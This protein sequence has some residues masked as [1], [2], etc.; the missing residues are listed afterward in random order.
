MTTVDQ[1]VA[2][3]IATRQLLAPTMHDREMQWHTYGQY[4]SRL[5]AYMR[6]HLSY[7]AQ[8]QVEVMHLIMIET[9]AY[10][11][12]EPFAVL[13]RQ[14]ANT[15]ELPLQFY[16]TALKNKV[17]RGHDFAEWLERGYY[18]QLLELAAKFPK[19]MAK[20]H[21][22]LAK[23]TL[24]PHQLA[25]RLHRAFPHVTFSGEMLALETAT[26]SMSITHQ[27]RFDSV[28]LRQIV[29]ARQTIVLAVAIADGYFT[30]TKT[31]YEWPRNWAAIGSVSNFLDQIHWMRIVAFFTITA[32]LPLELQELMIRM[33]LQYDGQG[34]L[35][36]C[37]PWGTPPKRFVATSGDI[38]WLRGLCPL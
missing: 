25:L 36:K 22:L 11:P 4:N 32:A 28:W 26:A 37:E 38:E 18:E 15:I 21:A 17:L 10:I 13:H 16:T 7:S 5:V 33:L 23:K 19:K 29:K 3:Y 8:L 9:Y 1:A 35:T 24:L 31:R 30:L 12:Y 20:L 27:V 34:R 2:A 6:E 14:V